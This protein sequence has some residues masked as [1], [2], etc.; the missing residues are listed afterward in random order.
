MLYD[1]PEDMRWES[2]TPSSHHG[3][4]IAEDV[5]ELSW[6]YADLFNHFMAQLL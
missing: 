3:F 6:T 1:I 4:D 5:N 2:A